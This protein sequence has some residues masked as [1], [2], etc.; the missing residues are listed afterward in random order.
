MRVGT[1]N[2]LERVI[3]RMSRTASVKLDQH[4]LD[5]FEEMKERGIGDN[6]T[7]RHKMVLD[8]G[9]RELGYLEGSHAMT[10]LRS[11]VRRVGEAFAMTGAMLMSVMYVMPL[12]VRLWALMPLFAALACY[13]GDKGLK[14]AEPA[15]SN[16]LFFWRGDGA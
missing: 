8:R 2:V 13:L 10:P 16:R 11:V 1:V 15:V 9:F 7:D 3:T 14:H 4:Y 5:A 6:H 12:E